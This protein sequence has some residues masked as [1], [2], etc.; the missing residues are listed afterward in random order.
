MSNSA[1]KIHNPVVSGV[2]KKDAD[3]VFYELTRSICP[4]CKKVIDAK[5]LLRDNKVFM[6]KRC[7]DCGP[8]EALVYGDAEAYTSF[9]KFNK[10]GTIPLAY[11]SEIKDGCPY[12]C[13]L[14]PDHQQHT[15][16]GIIEVNS[17]C[18]M[19]CP[20]CFS[21]AGPGF[22]L[23]LEEVEAMLDDFVRTEAARKSSSSQAAS[24]PSIRRSLTS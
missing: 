7:P 1:V 10:P 18:N 4:N 16:L 12:D 24:R 22:S 19:A 6:A 13:G 21:E 9:S 20:L 15:C 14:C 2:R 3:Y 17:A 23:T 8:F 11:G 5:I